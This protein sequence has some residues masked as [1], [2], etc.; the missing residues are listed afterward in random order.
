MLLTAS[1]SATEVW[2]KAP[3]VEHHAEQVRFVGR[4]L[5]AID[6]HPLVVAL[7]MVDV[8]H[9]RRSGGAVRR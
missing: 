2:V 9:P 1:R 3:R 6:E 4:G 8:Q 5:Q 7:Q